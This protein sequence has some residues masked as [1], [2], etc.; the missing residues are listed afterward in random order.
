MRFITGK[1]VRTCKPENA[2]S[3]YRVQVA[4]MAIPDKKLSGCIKK[5]QELIKIPDPVQLTQ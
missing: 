4:F 1:L 2:Q 5:G 3:Q